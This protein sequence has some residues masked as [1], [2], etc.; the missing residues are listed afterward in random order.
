MIILGESEIECV[1]LKKENEELWSD[2]N[3]CEDM[4]CC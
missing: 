3:E 2:L 1:V 4:D